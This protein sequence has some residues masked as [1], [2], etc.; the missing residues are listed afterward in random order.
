MEELKSI[1]TSREVLYAKAEITVNT[2][3]KTL[4]ESLRD[5]ATAVSEHGIL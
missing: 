3:G 1:L 5:L 4:D 2:S